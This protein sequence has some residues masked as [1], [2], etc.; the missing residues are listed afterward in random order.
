MTGQRKGRDF[1]HSLAAGI[2]SDLA[3]HS[4]LRGAAESDC[5]EWRV[6][7]FTSAVPALSDAGS[8]APKAESWCLVLVARKVKPGFAAL[9]GV[10]YSLKPQ[11]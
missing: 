3:S 5:L 6:S 11:S 1:V 2:P 4:G 7:C 8:L 10:N 9:S